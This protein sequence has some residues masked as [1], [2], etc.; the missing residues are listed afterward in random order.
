MTVVRL[1]ND[2][3]RRPVAYF[4]H[5]KGTLE[6]LWSGNR[7]WRHWVWMLELLK[8]LASHLL[9][10]FFWAQV[11]H[12]PPPP[13][14]S[15]SV[16]RTILASRHVNR[17][18]YFFMLCIY[19]VCHKNTA[20]VLLFCVVFLCF[21]LLC[22]VLL[23]FAVRLCACS[24]RSVKDFATF[25]S[26]FGGVALT[27]TRARFHGNT[28]CDKNACLGFERFCWQFQMSANDGWLW[29]S[30]TLAIHLRGNTKTRKL[31]L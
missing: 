25:L 6:K 7:S 22:F 3:K 21:A 24:S 26:R 1:C 13:L 15:N 10:F 20:V 17:N 5:V 12:D 8:L 27:P 19:T 11:F 28:C 2:V 23:C 9:C 14:H 18:L 4:F 16:K 29:A 30:Q 31:L